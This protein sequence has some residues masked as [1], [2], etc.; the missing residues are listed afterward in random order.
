MNVFV[1][2]IFVVGVCA[3]IIAYLWSD[4]KK[5]DSLAR[6]LREKLIESSEESL[7]LKVEIR[8]LGSELDSCQ[9]QLSNERIKSRQLE[10]TQTALELANADLIQYEERVSKLTSD[11]SETREF[12][13]LAYT[14]HPNLADEIAQHLLTEHLEEMKKHAVEYDRRFG[15]LNKVKKFRESD[16]KLA[17]KALDAYEELPE[18]ARLFVT[19][20]ITRLTTVL[21]ELDTE[22][23]T[24][25]ANQFTT[26]AQEALK[27]Y[28][29][30]TMYNQHIFEG[31]QEEYYKLDSRAQGMIDDDL[32]EEIS[33]RIIQAMN[34]RNSVS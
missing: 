21:E 1:I 30:G 25:T 11:I 22:N 10:S 32:I 5:A 2:F 34:H 20:D 26:R 13:S 3:A 27:S 18:E 17:R 16:Y 6:E 4:L 33:L 8:D 14:V 19:V 29:F 24:Q 7:R 31:L 28:P 9:D 15:R 23:A 12:L